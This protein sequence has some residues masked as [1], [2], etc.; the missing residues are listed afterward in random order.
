MTAEILSHQNGNVVSNGDLN[1]KNSNPNPSA[2]SKK[3][4]E[5]ER[6]RRRRKQKKNNKASQLEN[7]V[8]TV[9]EAGDSEDETKENSDHQ[10][11]S[12]RFLSWDF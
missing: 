9:S 2:A 7:D 5:S 3:S 11:V 12:N 10:Q 1:K 8:G 6:R 4:R